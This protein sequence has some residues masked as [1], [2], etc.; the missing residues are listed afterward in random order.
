MEPAEPS[1]TIQNSTSLLCQ[2]G[3]RDVISI[4]L[5][6]LPSKDQGNLRATCHFMVTVYNHAVYLESM[7]QQ[8]G[9]EGGVLV[10]SQSN[11]ETNLRWFQVDMKLALSPEFRGVPRRCQLL[12]RSQPTSL[13][14]NLPAVSYPTAN[15]HVAGRTVPYSTGPGKVLADGWFKEAHRLVYV[16]ISHLP[17]L[18]AI[19]RCC[20]DCCRSL[21][22]AKMCHL[23]SL[24]LIGDFCSTFKN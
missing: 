17:N 11:Q 18:E 22:E 3:M 5:N 14:N 10:A 4:S 6:F 2:P 12:G 8:E 7:T 20:L 21:V 15:L 13:D 24:K 9:R 23:P 1:T 19:R 16:E